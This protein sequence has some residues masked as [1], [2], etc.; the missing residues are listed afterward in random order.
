MV[1]S[2]YGGQSLWGQLFTMW[3][4]RKQKG[5]CNQD[6][7]YEVEEHIPTNLPPQ[8][9]LLIIHVQIKI[10]YETRTAD[11]CRKFAN[12]IQQHMEK[13]IYHDKDDFIPE[14]RACST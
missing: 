14:I 2:I 10:K 9:V 5:F 1:Y 8:E 6:P 7:D 11:R 12:W 13:I 4:I 3:K